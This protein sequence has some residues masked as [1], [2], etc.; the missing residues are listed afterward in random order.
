MLKVS[1]RGHYG[2]RLMTELARSY[3]RG[4]LSLTEV[5][6]VETLP[7]PYL[8]QLVVPLRR[9]G[10]VEGT[11]GLH[12]GYRLS[13]DPKKTSVGE[14]LRALEGPVSMVDCT[15]EDYVHGTCQ[16]EQQC[17]SSSLWQRLKVTVDAILDSTTLDDLLSDPGF[18][19]GVP[20]LPATLQPLAMI[21]VAAGAQRAQGR[22][23]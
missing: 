10:L 19:P 18:A 2:L 4:P 7:L 11:R 9:A 22:Q 17:M 14:I 21:P 16:R 3:G 12:G 13:T 5:A 20:Q 15:A 6:R 8:E 1:S 23:S